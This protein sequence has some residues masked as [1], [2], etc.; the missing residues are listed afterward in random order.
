MQSEKTL[1]PL[2][3]IGAGP[4]GLTLATHLL[5]KR[6]DTQRQF[7]VIDPSGGWMTQWQQRFQAQ[8]IPYLRSPAVHHPDPLAVQLR[9]FAESRANEL[10]DPYGRP[11]TKLFHD[12][13]Q[14]L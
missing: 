5:Q 11:G 8:E 9:N 6:K 10:H 7:Q 12:F 14:D 2:V 1:T 4:H 13:C 3:I